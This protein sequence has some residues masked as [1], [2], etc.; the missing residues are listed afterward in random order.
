M[1]TVRCAKDEARSLYSNTGYDSAYWR[2]ERG[3]RAIARLTSRVEL[4][5]SIELPTDRPLIFAANHSSLFDLVA[6]LI[7][8]GNY[9]IAARIAVN[10]RFFSNPVAGRFLRGIGCIPFSR[11]DRESAERTMVEALHDGQLCAL[12]PEGRISRFDDQVNG[13]GPGRPG[14]S[15]IA[16]KAGAAVLPVGIAGADRAWKPGT[17]LPKPRLGRHRVVITIGAPIEF[18]TDDHEHN[19]AQLMDAIGALVLAGRNQRA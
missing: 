18:E 9:G 19:A 17:I 14:V 5:D 12:M 11:D 7:T 2:A 10:S 16:R 15:R 6:A 13:V 8:I 3:S 4:P 1:Q